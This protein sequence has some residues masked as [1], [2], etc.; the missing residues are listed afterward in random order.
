VKVP[1]AVRGSSR[2]AFRA[3][4]T[5][6]PLPT[7]LKV[8]DTETMSDFVPC[9]FGGIPGHE[10]GQG[11]LVVAVHGWGGRPAQMAPLARMLAAEGYRVLV[12]QIPGHAGGPQTDI[13]QA[14]SALQ[15]LVEDAGQP[16]IVVAH[17]FAS[18]VLRLAFDPEMP[19]D[20]A[21]LAPALDVN[22]SLGVFGERLGLF[23][24]ARR[25][26][27]RRL[28][29]WDPTLWPTVSSIFPEQMPG[30]R[31]LIV[32][33]PEDVDASFARAA[34]LAA[35]RPSTTIVTIPGEGHNGILNNPDTFLAV[36]GFIAD[37]S[38]EDHT[39]A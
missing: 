26:L 2:F 19:Y 39:A 5:P 30:A 18:M 29:R 10:I 32:H 27:R 6:P 24:W 21:L 11:P 31:I 23:P 25:G 14:A 37:H 8:R 3:W 28:E 15:S 17:S 9:Y 34:E 12:P 36:A 7:R 4:L 20:V 1:L 13:K 35:I 16:E 38:I 33:D 22:D